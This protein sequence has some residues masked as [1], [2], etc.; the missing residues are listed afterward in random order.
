MHISKYVSCFDIDGPHSLLLSS[1]T[2]AAD[3]LDATSKKAWLDLTADNGSTPDQAFISGLLERGYVFP[4]QEAEAQLFARLVSAFHQAR[5]SEV[6]RLAVCPTYQ[7]NL[8]CK[9][10]YEGQLPQTSRAALTEKDVLH[11]FQVIDQAYGARKQRVSVELTG[12]EPLLPKN[13]AAVGRIFEES[14]RRGYHIGA[15]SNGVCLASH[16]ADLLL[17]YSTQV[18]FVQVTLDGPPD[19]HNARRTFANGGGTFDQVTASID[20]LVDHNIPTRLRV[21][22]DAANISQLSLLAEIVLQ[23]GW[24]A[25]GCLEC[26]IAPVLDHRGYSAYAHLTPEPELMKRVWRIRSQDPRVQ[27]VF[28]FRLFRVLQHVSGIIEEGRGFPSPCVQYCEANS[29]NF[30]IFGADGLIYACGEA[31]GN[32]EFAIGRFLPNY[33][34]WPDKEQLW[35]GRSIA[36]VPC[37]TD[38][39]IAGLCG[40]GCTFS[41][42]VRYGSPNVGIC[43]GAMELL[44]SYCRTLAQAGIVDE[45]E[46][47]AAAGKNKV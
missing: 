8:A 18:S 42:L 41:S 33:E 37:C 44:K 23:K 46:V 2:G 31:V 4:S 24:L 1:L 26:D 10:C 47:E 45:D 7:C 15:V 29:P 30:F 14:A 28:R 27:E 34:I 21:N 25:N 35:R 32:P 6:L 39:S 17:Q 13:K 36:S 12:G 9:Y 5:S 3:I 43:N 40:G 38:C 16:F 22:I 19:I 11:L 20:F